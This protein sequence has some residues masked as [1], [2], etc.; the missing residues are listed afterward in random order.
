MNPIRAVVGPEI[1]QLPRELE[2]VPIGHAIKVLTSDR[3]DE[4]LD[5]RMRNRR[6]GDRLDLLDLKHAQVGNPTV[7]PKQGIMVGADA[8]WQGLSGNRMLEHRTCRCA[9]NVCTLDAESDDSACEHIDDQQHPVT[10]Q[11]D[12]FAAK[13][14]HASEAVLGLCA[15]GQPGGT[16][17]SG[18]AGAVV[19]LKHSAH[20][21]LVDLGAECMSDLLSDAQVSEFGIAG[22]HLD[23]CRD[24][25]QRWPFRAGLASMN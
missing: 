6:V 12:G 19:L 4:T 11:K 21:I 22:L 18:V 9:V 25:F 20:D 10:A 2:R 3:A 14:I 1:I 17:G 23:D 16:K 15:E 7:K 24:E 8:L 13:Q 5:E